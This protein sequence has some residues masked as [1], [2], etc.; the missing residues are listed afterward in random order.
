[1]TA[2]YFCLL[3]LSL[4][5]EKAVPLPLKNPNAFRRT[6]KSKFLLADTGGL[7]PSTDTLDTYLQFMQGDA[8]GLLADMGTV[9]ISNGI[10]DTVAQFTEQRNGGADLTKTQDSWSLDFDRVKRFAFFGFLDGAVGHTWFIQL[11]NF[12]HG[13]DGVSVVYKVIADTVVSSLHSMHCFK[14][15]SIFH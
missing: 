1:M 4:F 11:D 5:L 10:S 2:V 14:Y 13:T 3:L 6:Q 8:T 7:I 12:I 15:L 9:F